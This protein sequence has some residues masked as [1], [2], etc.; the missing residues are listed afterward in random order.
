MTEAGTELQLGGAAAAVVLLA[1]YTQMLMGGERHTVC[2]P[3]FQEILTD[4]YS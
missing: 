3:A 4:F 1:V 2:S